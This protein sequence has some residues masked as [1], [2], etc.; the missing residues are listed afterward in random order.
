MRWH[1]KVA[2]A[3]I[4]LGGSLFLYVHLHGSGKSADLPGYHKSQYQPAGP[5]P[6]LPDTK[7]M[8]AH[9]LEKLLDE[10]TLRWAP[11]DPVRM[12]CKKAP[13][14]RWD[15]VCT[16]AYLHATFGVDVDSGAVTSFRLLKHGGR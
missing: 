10:D 12:Q 16:D 2:A 1:V 4:V 13:H 14:T 8:S 11:N 5:N 15:Y 9:E 6:Y 7:R 3:L